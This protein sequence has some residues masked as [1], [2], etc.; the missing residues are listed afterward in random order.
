[1]QPVTA[2]RLAMICRYAP[3]K[4]LR[5]HEDYLNAAAAEAEI[6]TPDR[7]AMFL[8]QVLH[9]CAEF[10]YLEEVWGPT[11]AQCHYEG[12][13]DLG[14]TEPGDGLR[15]K[16]RGTIQTTGRLNYARAAAALNLPL[17]DRPELLALPEHAH[18]AAAL[19]WRDHNLNALADDG[20]LEGCT[21]KI[22]GGLT[23]LDQR[24]TYYDRACEILG[25]P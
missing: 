13:K 17:L 22:N 11:P 18:R 20:D 10:R 23:G 21:R 9:E 14:N 3:M 24:E 8:A 19:Y 12:R 7:W 2:D 15:F 6:N 5:L 16:G 1:M 25:V 4:R